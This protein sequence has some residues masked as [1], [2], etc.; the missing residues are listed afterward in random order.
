MPYNTQKR[1]ILDVVTLFSVVSCLS[2]AVWSTN[3]YRNTLI[4]WRIL[5][6]IVFVGGIICALI[7]WRTLSQIGYARWAILFISFTCGGCLSH[8]GLLY[9]NKSFSEDNTVSYIFDIRRTG[10]LAKGRHGCRQPYAVIYFENIEKD[11]V[12][13]CDLSTNIGGFSKIKI[14]YSKGLFGYNVIK[15]KTLMK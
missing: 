5:V 7:F 10:S 13:P 1:N 12:F 11:L 4:D 3:I 9:L 8:F 2:L 15:T 14:Q 6:P